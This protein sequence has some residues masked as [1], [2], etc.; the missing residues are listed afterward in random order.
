[1]MS[2]IGV[3]NVDAARLRAIQMPVGRPITMQISTESPVMI[4]VS[5]LSDHRS[6]MPNIKNVM[7]TRIVDRSPAAT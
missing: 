6:R 2:R 7:V 5:M 3:T 4:S 1:M